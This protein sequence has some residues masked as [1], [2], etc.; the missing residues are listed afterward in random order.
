MEKTNEELIHEYK[1]TSRCMAFLSE[2]EK[3]SERNAFVPRIYLGGSAMN[4]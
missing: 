2:K 4:L 1:E 3:Y